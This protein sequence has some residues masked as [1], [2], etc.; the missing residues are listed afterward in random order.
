MQSKPKILFV[1]HRP[2][3]LHDSV[4]AAQGYQVLTVNSLEQARKH[5][6]PGKFRLILVEPNGNLN[7]ALHFCSESKK[8]DPDLRFAFMTPQGTFLPHAGSC[9]DDVITLKFDPVQFVQQVSEL[10]A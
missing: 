2:F 8:S 7:D 3:Q 6:A 9:P 1:S 4:L 5:W 10:I